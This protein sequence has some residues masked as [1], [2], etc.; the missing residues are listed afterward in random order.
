MRPLVS[1][2]VLE[3]RRYTVTCP[4][5]SESVVS[6]EVEELPV[7]VVLPSRI[8]MPGA[9]VR[10]ERPRTPENPAP[11]YIEEG[12]RIRILRE[13]E[14]MKNGLSVVEAEIIDPPHPRIW[15]LAKRELLGRRSEGGSG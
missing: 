15:L 7:R 5:L 12:E 1:Y 11:I 9:V 6:V 4:A 8:V 3:V 10:Y 2:K 13:V 14:N